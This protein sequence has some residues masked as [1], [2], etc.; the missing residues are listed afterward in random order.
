MEQVA[1]VIDP[2]GSEWLTVAEAARTVRVR[3]STIRV[4]VHRRKVRG[5]RMG[6]EAWVHMGDVRHAEAQ[7]V[8]RQRSAGHVV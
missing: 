6:R 8:Q 3:P 4:W 1:A 2:D 7:W 5:K